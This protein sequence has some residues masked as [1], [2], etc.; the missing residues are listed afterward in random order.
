M[1]PSKA[2]KPFVFKQFT[3]EQ[4]R[5]TMQVGTDGVLLG[6][7]API[8]AAKTVLDIGTGTGLI[9]I[10]L[11]QRCE[12]GLIHA[13]EIEEEAFQQAKENMGQAPWA[14][15][16][17]AH[18]GAIQDFELPKGIEEGFDLI[19]SNPPFFSGG[20]F[21]FNQDRNSVRHT[22]KLP[23]NDLLRAVR[24]LLNKGGRFA[25]ILPLLE[26]LRFKE[27][28]ESYHLYCTQMI[29]VQPKP[30]RSA[31]RLLLVFEKEAKAIPSHTSTLVLMQEDDIHRTEAYRSLTEAFYL[32]P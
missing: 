9:A 16:L 13:V 23:H 17:M 30:S 32:N 21:S 1:T 28:A 22:V 6:A 5:C 25:T 29:E 11:A 10:M 7:W 27:L 31:E 4:D 15:R 2:I 26:G 18:L 20:T 12:E 14:D 19:V 8:G 24:R 3:V